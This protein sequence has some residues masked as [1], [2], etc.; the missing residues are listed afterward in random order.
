MTVCHNCHLVINVYM[1]ICP[2]LNF[3]FCS[4]G[5]FFSYPCTNIILPDLLLLSHKSCYTFKFSSLRLRLRGWP[6][7]STPRFFET[8]YLFLRTHTRTLLDFYCNC[9]ETKDEFG[10]EMNIFQILSLHFLR[11]LMPL[12]N[13]LHFAEMVCIHSF[14]DHLLDT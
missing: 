7:P 6:A 12:G 2:F 11:S 3:L 1:C 4:I 8:T 14:D 5:L 13:F 9:F 10:G